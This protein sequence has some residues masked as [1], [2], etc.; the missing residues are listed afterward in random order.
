[1]AKNLKLDNEIGLPY[2]SMDISEVEEDI[3]TYRSRQ[4]A[5]R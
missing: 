1:M 2:L 4:G 3:E 5:D